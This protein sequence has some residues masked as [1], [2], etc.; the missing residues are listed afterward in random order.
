VYVGLDDETATVSGT[1]TRGQTVSIE[2][3]VA[4]LTIKRPSATYE[5]VLSAATDEDGADTDADDDTDDSD[6]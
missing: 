2:G 6:D 5:V 3:G 4:T 1:K